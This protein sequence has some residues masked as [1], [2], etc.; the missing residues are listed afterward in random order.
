MPTPTYPDLAVT[1]AWLE[2]NGI[3]PNDV[4]LDSAITEGMDSEG[5]PVIRYTALLRRDGR[6]YALKGA[7]GPATE[8]REVPL[9]TPRSEA[10]GPWAKQH[11]LHVY[12]QTEARPGKPEADGTAWMD[13]RSAGMVHLLCNCGYSTGW[14]SRRDMPSLEQLQT[15]HAS[16]FRSTIG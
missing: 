16:P 15:D 4:P 5:H 9:I 1:V 8:Q 2:A 3:D 13:V 7:A 10:P 14:I 12:N 11:E 6:P